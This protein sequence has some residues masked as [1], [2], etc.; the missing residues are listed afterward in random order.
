MQK[1]GRV[2]AEGNIVVV[3][4]IASWSVPQRDYIM[5][6][7]SHL[8]FGLISGQS[9]S[10]LLSHCRRI[11]VSTNRWDSFLELRTMMTNFLLPS[12]R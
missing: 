5:H 2:S 8:S 12:C 11:S 1:G 3:F 7:D 9:F 4:R 10:F 6:H